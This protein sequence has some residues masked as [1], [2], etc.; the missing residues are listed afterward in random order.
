MQIS[1]DQ[2]L[3][4]FKYRNNIVIQC[5]WSKTKL[6]FRVLQ[7]LFN[8]VV[9]V[10][11]NFNCDKIKTKQKLYKKNLYTGKFCPSC[12]ITLKETIQIFTNDMATLHTIGHIRMS[13]LFPLIHVL[14]FELVRR[15][16]FTASLVNITIRE[17]VAL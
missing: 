9:I 16:F 13:I 7:N 11:K 10:R 3:K 14:A 17:I 15:T 8:Y 12:K 1:T 4:S 2:T 5:N 6:Q